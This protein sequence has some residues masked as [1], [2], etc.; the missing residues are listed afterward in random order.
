[1]MIY[2]KVLGIL[3]GIAAMLKPIYMHLLP[4]DENKFPAN[5][6][7]K[8]RLLW[9]VPVTFFGLIMVA[10]TWYVELN[11]DLTYSMIFTVIFTLAVMRILVFLFDYQ[12]FYKWLKR[13]LMEDRGKKF[14]I[15]DLWVG[16]LGLIMVV[17][18][19]VLY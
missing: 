19:I 1:M 3:I 2:F 6:L 9:I 16:E 17:L 18:S 11:T 15:V 5:T 8:K 4:W 7:L 13:K 12:A 14:V 10:C